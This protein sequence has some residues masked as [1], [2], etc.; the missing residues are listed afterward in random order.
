MTD[1]LPPTEPS[2]RTRADACPGALQLHEAADGLLARVR[3]PG[4]ELTSHQLQVLATAS[5][6]LADGNLVLTS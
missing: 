2:A 5:T 4:G 3:L 6:E 1:Q